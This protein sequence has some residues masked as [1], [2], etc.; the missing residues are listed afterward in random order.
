MW[1]MKMI[2][3]GNLVGRVMSR[4]TL[5]KRVKSLCESGYLIRTEAPAYRAVCKQV[6]SI[7]GIWTSMTQD[8]RERAILA[9]ERIADA[10]EKIVSGYPRLEKK[11]VYADKKDESK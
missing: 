3:E 1:L 2:N 5:Q 9:L 8:Q 6:L 10:T 7:P 11:I 4:I